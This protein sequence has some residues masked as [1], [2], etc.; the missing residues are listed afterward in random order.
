[1]NLFW[2]SIV[3]DIASQS[4][5]VQQYTPLCVLFGKPAKHIVEELLLPQRKY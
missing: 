4:W 3:H 5:G 1:M 2:N